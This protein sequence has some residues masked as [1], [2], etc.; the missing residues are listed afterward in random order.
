MLMDNSMLEPSDFEQ[1]RRLVTQAVSTLTQCKGCTGCCREMSYAAY[2]S[3]YDVPLHSIAKPRAQAPGLWMT[4]K[5][6]GDCSHLNHQDGYGCG[7]HPSRNAEHVWPIECVI[8]PFYALPDGRILIAGTCM[9]IGD[10]MHK[11]IA[12]DKEANAAACILH[13]FLPKIMPPSLSQHWAEKLKTENF[14][15][16]SFLGDPRVRHEPVFD[17]SVA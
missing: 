6:N 11:L 10:I 15:V 4:S 7:L 12:R 5:A 3:E 2:V 17:H 9:H 8:Y 14:I 1:A 13:D 16:T